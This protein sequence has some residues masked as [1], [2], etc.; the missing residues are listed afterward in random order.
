VDD[1]FYTAFLP[2]STRVCGRRLSTFSGWH[3]FLLSAIDS[4]FAT[5]QGDITPRDLLVALAIL[6]NRYPQRS[7]KARWSDGL[8]IVVLSRYP[9]LFRAH[10]ERLAMWIKEQASRP[11]IIHLRDGSTRQDATEG[12]RILSLVCSLVYT[13]RMPMAEAWDMPMGAAMW[14]DAEMSRMQGARIVYMDD[15]ASSDEPIDMDNMTDEQALALFR[16]NLPPELVEAS[17]EHWQ[18]QR[19]GVA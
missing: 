2:A 8:W 13:T 1:R 5:G 17:F 11:D 7:T 18:R 3:H 19:G 4:P 16:T 15:A 12:P 9:D 6:Q 10:C 14:M